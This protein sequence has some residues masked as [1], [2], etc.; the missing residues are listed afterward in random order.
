VN[1]E[2]GP[3]QLLD[4]LGRGGMGEVYRAFDSSTNRVV[5]LKLLPPHL[6]SDEQFRQRFLR[7]AQIAAGLNEAHVVPIHRYGEIDGRLYV[8]MRLIEGWDLS[9]VLAH[10]PMQPERALHILDQVA[11]ALDAAH[12]AG[13]VHRD[14]K[15]SNILLTDRD[16]AY[17]IDFGIAR[18]IDDTGLTGTGQAIG[19]FG[20]MA[21]ERFQSGPTDSR[22]DVYALACVLYECL[23]GVKVFGTGS[24]AQLLAAHMNS[25]PPRPSA[26]GLPASLDGVIATGMA[27][28]PAMRFRSP[29]DLAHAARHAL[30]YGPPT[31]AP[32][33]PWQPPSSA[34]PPSRP[35]ATRR[36]TLLVACAATLVAA[37]A[38]TAFTIVARESGSDA[39][40]SG[41]P[42]SSGPAATVDIDNLLLGLP[43]LATITGVQDLS[44]VGR[45]D[46]L[47]EDYGRFTSEPAKCHSVATWDSRREFGAAG[48]EQLRSLN[49]AAPTNNYISG[50]SEIVYQ[51]PSDESAS[52]FFEGNAKTWKS[53]EGTDYVTTDHLDGS[54]AKDTISG[55]TREGDVVTQN[56][57]P[58]DA[59][60]GF[61]CQQALTMRSAFVVRTRMCGFG[62]TDQGRAIAT[63]ITD[64]IPSDSVPAP[65]VP[66]LPELQPMLLNAQEAGAALGKNLKISEQEDG[67]TVPLGPAVAVVPL[68]CAE[69][70]TTAI[71]TTYTDVTWESASS[72]GFAVVDAPPAGPP[73]LIMQGIVRASSSSTAEQFLRRS[74]TE[75]RRCTN[76]TFTWGADSLNKVSV[77][78]IEP[79]PQRITANI[80]QVGG[81][82]GCSHTL[83]IKGP[84]VVEAQVCGDPPGNAPAMADA[85]LAKVP[86]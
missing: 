79:G 60:Q 20:Y 67:L 48:I 13:L 76:T 34:P 4:L 23:T 85:I 70:A 66:K 78:S 9:A 14:V 64:R 46:N 77:Q 17:L 63:K 72:G 50:A 82:W 73:N 7:E 2:F 61:S 42:T 29:D 19:S 53:C 74:E 35:T 41:T 37:V 16:F 24:P 39:G 59:P 3:Y 31:A 65:P 11:A 38:V 1:P 51:F 68:A 25:P 40:T 81:R 57:T 26:A 62:I 18:A 8:D 45:G 30:G 75:W 33:Q 36:R 71:A 5:A 44:I 21:P 6:A 12:R 84:Y 32:T 69:V 15:P 56:R 22:A 27:K 52:G 55:F 86:G 54:K 10:G 80:L 83:A 49:V 28:D 47:Y 58:Q 43:E